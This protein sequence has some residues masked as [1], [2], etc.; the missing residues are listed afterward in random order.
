MDARPDA[1]DTPKLKERMPTLRA[2]NPY[3]N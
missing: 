1:A 2:Q 3:I